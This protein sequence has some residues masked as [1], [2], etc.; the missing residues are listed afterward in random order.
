LPMI[1]VHHARIVLLR[2]FRCRIGGSVIGHNDFIRLADG[3]RLPVTC[4][5][6]TPAR[7]AQER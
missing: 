7:Y 5:R 3:A 4:G 1:D 2:D 6:E